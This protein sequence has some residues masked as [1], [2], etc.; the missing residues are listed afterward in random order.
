MWACLV[1]QAYTVGYF[2][3]HCV[4]LKVKY[5][6]KVSVWLSVRSYVHVVKAQLNEPIHS[7]SSTEVYIV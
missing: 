5:V 2:L 3:H 1:K 7:V 6:L 4:H